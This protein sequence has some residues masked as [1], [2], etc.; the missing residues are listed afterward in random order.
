VPTNRLDLR[1]VTPDFVAISFY[2][3]FGYPTGVGCLLVRNATLEPAAPP[4]VCRRTVNFTTVHGQRHVLS[5]GEAGFEDG[6]L[7]YLS[8]PAVEIGLRHLARVGIDTI[9]TR[10]NCLTE[11]VVDRAVAH[12]HGNGRPMVRI[13]GPASP[14]QPRRHDITRIL[15]SGR[16]ACST[17]AASKSSPAT[18]DCRCAPAASA[19]PA[20][21][22]PRKGDRRGMRAAF[23]SDPDLTL[24]RFLHFM[25]Q[26]NGKSTGAVRVRWGSS[27]NVSDVER[28]LAF[29]AGFRDRTLDALGGLTVDDPIAA[30][31]ATAAE[32]RSE[33]TAVRR[34]LFVRLRP[35]VHAL[36]AAGRQPGEQRA[37]EHNRH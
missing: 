8:I 34:F 17:T 27:A 24:P 15:R 5:S 30:S 4:V 37:D 2:K 14:V 33:Q 9:Q 6:T 1:V 21:A 29:A 3:M 7:N 10:V 16:P 32:R 18:M 11:V 13:Y 12:R 26:R 31:S 36:E 23:A 20:R 35:R 28:F 25:Q 19:I 22:R